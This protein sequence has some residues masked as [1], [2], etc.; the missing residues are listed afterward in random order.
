MPLINGQEFNNNNS[1]YN[2]N[3]NNISSFSP[4]NIMSSTSVRAKD[5]D[6]NNTSLE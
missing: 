6:N 3:N 5:K 2:Y 4:Y 1:Y